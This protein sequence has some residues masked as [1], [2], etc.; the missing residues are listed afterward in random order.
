MSTKD[1][2]VSR[3]AHDYPGQTSQGREELQFDSRLSLLQRASLDGTWDSLIQQHGLKFSMQGQ[4]H[5]VYI[6][7]PGQMFDFEAMRVDRLMQSSD[8]PPIIGVVSERIGPECL[9]LE[10]MNLE[11]LRFILWKYCVAD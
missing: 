11:A 2:V 7:A 10:S 1:S 3:K 4:T 6:K 8:V 5:F 9:Y